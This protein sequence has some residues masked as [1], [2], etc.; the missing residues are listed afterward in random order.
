[1]NAAQQ[2]A[3]PKEL[4]TSLTAGRQDSKDQAQVEAQEQTLHDEPTIPIP[5]SVDPQPAQPQPTIEYSPEQTGK[6]SLPAEDEDEDQFD[7]EEDFDDEDEQEAEPTFTDQDRSDLSVLE[8]KVNLHG[9]EQAKAIREIRKRKLWMLHRNDDGSRKYQSYDQYVQDV[10]GHS[11]QWATEQTQWLTTNEKL[12]DLRT[13]GKDVPERLTRTGVSGMHHLAECGNYQGDT[14]D[15]QEEAGLIAVLQE[16]A[17]GGKSLSGDNLR[18]ICN[19]RYQ[20]FNRHR[21]R[22]KPLALTYEDYK[23]DLALVEPLSKVDRS[24]RNNAK[25]K[26]WAETNNATM[27]EAVVA[28]YKQHCSLPDDD[29]LLSVATGDELEKMVANLVALGDKIASLQEAEKVAK[30]SREK[31]RQ[32]RVSLGV[33]TKSRKVKSGTPTPPDPGPATEGGEDDADAEEVNEVQENLEDAL[34][35]LDSALEAEWPDPEDADMIQAILHSV[36][37]CEGKLAEITNKAKELLATADKPMKVIALS[38][39]YFPD[40]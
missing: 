35:D 14:E 28:T 10:H 19:R 18:A 3:S 20:F 30:E 31:A 21:W 17:E 6:E 7:D 25:V 22:P 23:N 39:P 38:D 37:S 13:Q 27:Q 15:E 5:E 26:E 2:M 24:E 40:D 1:M 16:A 34:D 11:R 12:G 9:L 36:H 33:P 8:A 29:F 4:L 32:T